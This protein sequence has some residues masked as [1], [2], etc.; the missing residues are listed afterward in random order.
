MEASGTGN[1]KFALNG[2]L[3]IGTLDGANVEIKEHVG[4]DNIFI[5]GLTAG[6]VEERRRGG[7]DAPAIIDG[8][9]DL[10]GVL[11]ALTSGVYS[12]DDHN[13]YRPIADSLYHGDWFMVAADFEAYAKAQRNVAALWRKPEDWTEK[14]IL[15]TVNMGWFSSDRTIRDYARD[16]WRVPVA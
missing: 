12:P 4:D 3:T 9:P 7:Q 1:M 15:N 16:I 10:K 13:R 11:D 8:C 2:A 14:T 5:F 6:E